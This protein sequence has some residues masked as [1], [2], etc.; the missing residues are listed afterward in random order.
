[1]A[2]SPNQGWAAL[3]LT[4]ASLTASPAIAAVTDLRIDS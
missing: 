3:Y 2:L 1:V 4:L